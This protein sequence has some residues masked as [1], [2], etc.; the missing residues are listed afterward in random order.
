MSL[1]LFVAAPID[2]EL[3]RALRDTVSR[4]RRDPVTNDLR[5]TDPAGWHLTVAFLGDRPDAHVERLASALRSA[6]AGRAPVEL[7][8]G[9]L[10]A[11]PSPRAARVVWYR[12]DDSSGRLAALA[13]D[14]RRAVDA[15]GAA[16]PWRPHLTLA[17]TPGAAGRPLAAWL[18]A[19]TSPDG[20]LIVDRLDLMRSRLGG[21]PAIYETM[22]SVVFDAPVA[23]GG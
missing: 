16:G 3:R 13:V 17:R 15:N 14:V 5:W 7:R 12:F 9:G 19:Q 1:R 18:A 11:F 20:R 2:D 23:I 4:M 22:A 21:G 8:G 6:V 10:G